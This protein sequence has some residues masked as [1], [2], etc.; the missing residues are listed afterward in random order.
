[1]RMRS[2]AQALFQAT[3]PVRGATAHPAVQDVKAPIS[4]HAPRE[5]S[6]PEGEEDT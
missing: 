3:L 2:T 1:M 5:G 6:D 4:I